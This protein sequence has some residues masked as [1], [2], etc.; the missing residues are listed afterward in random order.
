MS[1]NAWII[2]IA[3]CVLILGGLVWMSGRNK[4][5]VSGVDHNAILSASEESGDIADHVKGNA[6]AKVL[7][8]EYG[9]FQCPGCRSA[10]PAMKA[11]IDK[12]SDKVGFVF[13]NFPLAIHN[14][15]RAAAA[16]AEAAGL[17]GKYWEMHDRLFENQQEWGNLS[18]N[19]RTD[20]FANY[21]EML[22]LD[23]E[24][25]LEDLKSDAV[26]A[27]INFDV[28]L[29]RKIGVNS[30]PSIFVNG[31]QVKDY[32]KDGKIVSEST[33]GANILWSNA[34]AF[35]ELVLMPALRD[36]GVELDDKD[37]D[38]KEDK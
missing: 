14:N 18:G 36:A 5:D 25:F 9:D 26:I 7:I 31:K 23:R 13:R 29:G 19:T 28:S 4:V 6:E 2:F 10:A 12:Y 20:M 1:R 15:A 3:I 22:E 8:I 21:A 30:T 17:Q 34:E 33:P 35:E 32:Y 27:K 11:V 37:T 24:K 38:K 16:A